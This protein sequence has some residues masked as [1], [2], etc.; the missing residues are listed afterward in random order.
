M[1]RIRPARIEEF[2]PGIPIWHR[3]PG[4]GARPYDHMRAYMEQAV[5]RPTLVDFAE[6]RGVTARLIEGYSTRCR[7]RERVEAYDSSVTTEVRAEIVR[8]YADQAGDIVARQTAMAD[9]LRD[10]TQRELEK[11]SALSQSEATPVLTMRTILQAVQ[12]VM[13]MDRLI[14]NDDVAKRLPMPDLGRL[15]ITDV[16]TLRELA[17]KATGESK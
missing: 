14:T 6:M 1:P 9:Q 7:W 15:T 11:M 8:A 5:P 2:A 4:E 10:L 16:A 3:Q 12:L 13:A 17:I